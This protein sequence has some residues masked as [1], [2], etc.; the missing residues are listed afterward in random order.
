M[1]QSGFYKRL[2][3]WERIAFLPLFFFFG[4]EK[5]S[6]ILNAF[7][8]S[9]LFSGSL[10]HFIH[11]WVFSSKMKNLNL[12]RKYAEILNSDVYHKN[13]LFIYIYDDCFSASN[14]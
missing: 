12:A 3:A 14:N 2:P 8:H 9:N 1:Q 6:Q 5:N 7:S 10:I 4:L 13:M 11:F